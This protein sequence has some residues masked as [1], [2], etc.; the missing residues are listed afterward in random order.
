MPQLIFYNKNDDQGVRR[1]DTG[2]R[3]ARWWRPVASKVAL[4]LLHRAMCLASHRRIVV[5]HGR[6]IFVVDVNYFV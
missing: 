6:G 5:A 2:R 3:L 1:G 4:N